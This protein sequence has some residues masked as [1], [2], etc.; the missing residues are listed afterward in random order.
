M[1]MHAYMRLCGCRCACECAWCTRAHGRMC[2]CVHASHM[3]HDTNWDLGVLDPCAVEK[4]ALWCQLRGL[5]GSYL[6][7][8]LGRVIPLIWCNENS[9]CTPTAKHTPTTCPCNTLPFH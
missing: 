7:Y 9:T 3:Q 2:A 4:G 6:Q 5:W 1:H 8:A